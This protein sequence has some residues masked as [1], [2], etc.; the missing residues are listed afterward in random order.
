MNTIGV[1]VVAA[2]AAYAAAAA[3]VTST[4]RFICASS[5]AIALKRSGCSAGKRWWK[6]T[7]RPST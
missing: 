6:T 4:S 7:F 1:L 2:L 3:D 5:A